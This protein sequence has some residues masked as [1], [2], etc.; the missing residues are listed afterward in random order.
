MECDIPGC[1]PI[2]TLVGFYS[3]GASQ[4]STRVVKMGPRGGLCWRRWRS[5]VG[6]QHDSDD[7]LQPPPPPPP[8]ASHPAVLFNPT[9]AHAHPASAAPERDAGDDFDES[10]TV[11][12]RAAIHAH[13]PAT[14]PPPRA[15]F[16][17]PSVHSLPRS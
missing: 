1:A 6:S 11:R 17:F 14:P 7:R 13:A 16:S 9:C 5:T 2:E 3:E 15:L 10:R 12:C 4:V 8:L